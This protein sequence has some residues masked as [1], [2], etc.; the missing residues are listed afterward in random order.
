MYCDSGGRLMKRIMILVLGLMLLPVMAVAVTIHVPADQPTIQAGIDAA[1]DGDTVFIAPGTYGVDSVVV[2]NKTLTMRG[3]FSPDTVFISGRIVIDHADLTIQKVVISGVGSDETSMS[4]VYGGAMR[5]AFSNLRADSIIIQKGTAKR[6]GAIC[7]SDG[8]EI[9]ISHSVV[10]GRVVPDESVYS[11]THGMGG[12]IYAQSNEFRLM[13]CRIDG[14]C[15]AEGGRYGGDAT[16]GGIYLQCSSVCLTDNVITGTAHC[17]M[18]AYCE[19]SG[20]AIWCQASFFNAYN[21]DLSGEVT[22]SAY[23]E[24]PGEIPYGYAWGGA[25]SLMTGSGV[26]RMNTVHNSFAHVN[27]QS[28]QGEG[29]ALARGGGLYLA[30]GSTFSVTRCSFDDNYVTVT[31]INDSTQIAQGGAIYAANLCLAQCNEFSGNQPDDVVGTPVLGCETLPKRAWL[32]SVDGDNCMG[33]GSASRPFSQI[34]SAINAA[35]DGDT[36]LV[37]PGIYRGIGN[38]NMSTIGKAI[39]VKGSAGSYSTILSCDGD[40]SAFTMISTNE[41]SSTVIEG[42][43][44]TGAFN[45]MV[46]NGSAPR[47]QDVSFEHNAASG[48]VVGPGSGPLIAL[49]GCKFVENGSSGVS[50]LGHAEVGFKQCLFS[51]NPT[52]IIIPD[53]HMMISVD[54]CIFE[55][56]QTALNGE[57]VVNNSV[58]RNG[59]RGTQ[60]GGGCVHGVVMEYHFSN[61]LFEGI[62]GVVIEAT[63]AGTDLSRCTIRNNPGAISSYTGGYL[64]CPHILTF[65]DCT[66]EGNGGGIAA[67]YRTNVRLTRCIYVSNG[68][69]IAFSTET[70]YSTS[71]RVESSTI[72]NNLS[73]GLTIDRLGLDGHGSWIQNTLIANNT[74]VG[75]SC[76]DTN[77]NMLSFACNDVYGNLQGDYSGIPDQTGIN[78][79]ISLD[80]RFCDADNGNFQVQSSSPCAPSNNNCGVLIGALGIGCLC[81]EVDNDGLITIADVVFLINYIFVGGAA[82]QP[83]WVGDVDCS[84]SI[85]IA[86]VVYLINYIFSGGAA[87]CSAF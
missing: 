7:V 48:M 49:R 63:S 1:A 58:I 69:S 79:N 44:I 70:Y 56:N 18:S 6:G 26:F 13:G 10:N 77:L 28:W 51:G 39:V 59:V 62:T 85:N 84:G 54:S 47:I 57:F 27:Y 5:A 45:G 80:P 83:L 29:S 61:C 50:H 64:D 65:T 33:D 11:G 67:S 4:E 22:V 78:G 17:G 40:S 41:D 74:G 71:L 19:A 68:G 3:L 15:R 82:P 16:G 31:D 37:A 38:R 86:D 32:V 42:F 23:H 34:Q 21:N 75:F 76:R 81:G 43:T 12:A 2:L 8:G 35:T 46:L 9:A 72:A 36:V 14:N 30:C 20:G 66:I 87:P 25:I 73:G 24:R 60:G 53:K 55:G 52:G